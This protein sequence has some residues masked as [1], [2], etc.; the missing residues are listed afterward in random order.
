MKKIL[1]AAIILFTSLIAFSSVSEAASVSPST[2]TI[3]G[4]TATA[5]WGFTW[6]QSGANS[7]SYNPGDGSGT[8]LK[9]SNNTSGF[10]RI[11]HSYVNHS[12]YIKYTASFRAV[13]KST[14]TAEVAYATVEKRLP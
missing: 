12:S 1:A 14:G 2:Q 13:Q 4:S 6:N 5:N 8:H 11:T 10:S 3:R 7:V 9:D